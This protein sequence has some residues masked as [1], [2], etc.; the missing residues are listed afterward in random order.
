MAT[1][2][3][4]MQQNILFLSRNFQPVSFLTITDAHPQ[5][6]PGNLTETP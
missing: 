4:K 1:A 3:V 5:L 6:H 2:E